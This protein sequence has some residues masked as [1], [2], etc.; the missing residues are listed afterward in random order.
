MSLLIQSQ[1]LTSNND[2][3]IHQLKS[4][5]LSN[6]NIKETLKLY[7]NACTIDCS[8]VVQLYFSAWTIWLYNSVQ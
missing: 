7:F 5:K 8:L 6:I 3:I 1:V 2:N 4:N